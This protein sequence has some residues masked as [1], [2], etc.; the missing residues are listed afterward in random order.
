MPALS[1]A[2]SFSAYSKGKSRSEERALCSC[3]RGSVNFFAH[4][5]IPVYSSTD[6]RIR[7][8][9]WLIRRPDKWLGATSPRQYPQRLLFTAA[10]DWL[11]CPSVATELP[12]RPPQRQWA[13]ACRGGWGRLD[14]PLPWHTMMCC[15]KQPTAVVRTSPPW[16][17]R[18]RPPRKRA[19]GGAPPRAWRAPV[20]ATRPATT[21]GRQ[22]L[23]GG[24]GRGCGFCAAP[25]FAGVAAT[26]PATRACGATI[27]G[28]GGG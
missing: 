14:A 15:R 27:C 12:P 5:S 4:R 9:R 8:K 25:V 3:I 28:G 1:V 13:R 18:L 24:S 2:P 22:R 26:P 16:L 6:P 21:G 10:A 7:A 17:R 19:A 23:V 11:L 20:R